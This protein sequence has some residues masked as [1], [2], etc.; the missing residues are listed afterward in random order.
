MCWPRF[1]F[2]KRLAQQWSEAN[3]LIKVNN[4][5]TDKAYEAAIVA[6]WKAGP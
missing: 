3:Q 4:Q 6:H 5:F 2:P 1:F